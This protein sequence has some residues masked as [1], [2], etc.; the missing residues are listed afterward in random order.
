MTASVLNA[1]SPLAMVND[2]GA[3]NNGSRIATG[4]EFS[5]SFLQQIKS[6]QSQTSEITQPGSVLE[7]IAGLIKGPEG[8]DFSALL[9]DALPQIKQQ[10]QAQDIN[11]DE[12]MTALKA[13]VAQLDALNIDNKLPVMTQGL[14]AKLEQ[15]GVMVDTQP[16]VLASTEQGINNSEHLESETSSLLTPVS[17]DEPV[18]KLTLEMDENNL[19]SANLESETPSL[20][21]P[22]SDEEPVNKLTLEMDENNLPKASSGNDQAVNTLDLVAN[23]SNALTQV[24]PPSALK[25]DEP[26]HYSDTDNIEEQI[27]QDVMTDAQLVAINVVMPQAHMMTETDNQTIAQAALPQFLKQEKTAVEDKVYT[28]AS[29]SAEQSS[30]DDVTPAINLSQL[31][32]R[33]K[34]INSSHDF[35]S[36]VSA[37]GTEKTLDLPLSGGEQSSN[38][39]S[40]ADLMALNR[41]V[42]SSVTK[43]E[44][45]PMTKPF[46]HPEWK[47][48]FNERIIWMHTKSIPS[49]ELRLNPQNLGPISIQI[50]ID[51]DKQA[52]IV[53]NAQNA[54]VREAIETSIPKLREML[55]AQQVNLAEV[56]VSQQQQQGQ[57]GARQAMQDAMAE[58]NRNNT[59]NFM[60]AAEIEP[61]MNEIAE[62][63]NQGRAVASKGLLSIYA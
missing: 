48:E 3:L 47:Q 51:K 36:L 31:L 2:S 8:Q 38:K 49:A 59:R 30:E 54:G 42:E 22:V 43:Q 50:T 1:L 60:G 56:N 37:K 15:G 28:Q 6:L 12:T 35:S 39:F 19:P 16:E 5:A 21:T 18:N 58:N 45:P 57:G 17:D 63:I 55:N 62:E 10:M 9:G 46:N 27:E 7:K 14:A 41:Q 25:A 34:L 40:T 53:F 11:L 4:A 44:L 13:I 26:R 23:F 32:T 24:N 33:E 61:E 52:S 29:L 20:L